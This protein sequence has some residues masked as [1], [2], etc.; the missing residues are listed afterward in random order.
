MHHPLDFCRRSESIAF[1]V[2]LVITLRGNCLQGIDLDWFTDTVE[3]G[4]IVTDLG[5]QLFHGVGL[6]QSP[7]IG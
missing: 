3:R 2:L 7:R 5:V 1:E 6:L 4:L